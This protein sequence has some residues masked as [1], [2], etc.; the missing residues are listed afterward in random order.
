M[1]KI[2]IDGYNLIHSIPKLKNKLNSDLESAR[3]DLTDM[4]FRYKNKKK[5]DITVVFD[6]RAGSIESK[7][8]KKGIVVYFSHAPEKADQVIKRLIDKNEKEKGVMVVSSDRE[9]FD[10]A[11][12]CGLKRVR[13][14]NFTDK[15]LSLQT[16]SSTSKRNK[17]KTDHTMSNEELQGWMDLFGE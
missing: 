17:K 12:M 4:L 8:R 1:K 5:V 3:N 2:I 10:Y 14:D 7:D 15:L 16:K 9:I 11:K 6:G 13:S